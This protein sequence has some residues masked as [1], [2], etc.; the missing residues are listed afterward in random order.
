MWERDH[1]LHCS[2]SAEKWLIKSQDPLELT[3]LYTMYT[4][5]L[6]V[7][8]QYHT[9]KNASFFRNLVMIHCCGLSSFMIVIIIHHC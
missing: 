4:H 3:S 1:T 9:L 2:K 5:V 7:L 8:I 6:I